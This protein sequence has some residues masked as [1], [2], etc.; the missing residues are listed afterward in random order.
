MTD[1]FQE[2]AWMWGPSHEVAT[3][4][5]WR[6]NEPTNS[7]GLEHFAHLYNSTWNYQ[8]NDSNNH[9]WYK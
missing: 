1:V 6:T 5:N 8:W 4:F 3:Y 9:A 2:G 7:G